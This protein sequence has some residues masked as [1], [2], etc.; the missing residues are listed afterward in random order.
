M[1]FQPEI[2]K[3]TP[4]R[5]T[6]GTRRELDRPALN[7]KWNKNTRLGVV[8][9]AAQNWSIKQTMS[10]EFLLNYIFSA[11]CM[12]TKWSPCRLENE[13]VLSARCWMRWGGEAVWSLQRCFCLFLSHFLSAPTA[14][15]NVWSFF[16]KG[17]FIYYVIFLKSYNCLFID[18]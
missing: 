5:K 14:T 3:E 4:R 13:D 12:Q 2:S 1:S 17:L 6:R 7:Y 8:L 18:M 15:I 9:S 11:P 10:A 16:A